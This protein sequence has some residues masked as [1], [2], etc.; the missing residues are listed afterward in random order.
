MGII[1]LDERPDPFVSGDIDIGALIDGEGLHQIERVIV[2]PLGVVLVHVDL[3]A[4]VAAGSS[5]H[6]IQ[7]IC[8]CDDVTGTQRP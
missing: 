2:E 8:R 3:Y 5:E 7:L 1:R 4:G 6:A